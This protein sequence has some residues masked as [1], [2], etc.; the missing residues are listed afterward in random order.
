MPAAYAVVAAAGGREC[1]YAA[2]RVDALVRGSVVFA[3]DIVD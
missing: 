2:G 3:A 1:A